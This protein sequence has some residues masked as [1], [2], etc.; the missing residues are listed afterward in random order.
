MWLKQYLAIG[1]KRPTW[2]MVA[3]DLIAN[4]VTEAEGA[5]ESEERVNIFTQHWNPKIS[6]LP[7]D[8]KAMIMIA[9][10]YGLRQE[11]LAF[12]REILRSMPMWDH[13]QTDM[14]SMRKLTRRTAAKRCLMTN[15]RARTVGDF[16][17]IAEAIREGEHQP[18]Q[19]CACK[20][21]EKMIVEDRCSNPHRCMARAKRI[22]DLLPPKWDPRG[23][24]PQD[25]EASER[26]R[27]EEEVAEGVAF[28]RTITTGGAIADT[29]RI[30]TEGSEVCNERLDM[31]RSEAGEWQTVAT[32][33][34]CEK[35][36]YADARAGAGVFV[37]DGD[38]RNI[39]IRVPKDIEQTNQ[40]GEALA[41]LLAT[42][43][44]E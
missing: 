35:N 23:E 32:D 14:K 31:K 2:A 3:D 7:R 16:E 12:T 24:H 4:T 30:F 6:A 29:F 21:C 5:R 20:R 40:V 17:N 25:H 18:N 34:A 13:A 39:S 36:G 43:V 33:G 9:R 26:Q 41:A 19:R 28:D 8:L 11:G 42:K 44:V 38:E 15:H 1:R 22:L 37:G 27:A 10:K